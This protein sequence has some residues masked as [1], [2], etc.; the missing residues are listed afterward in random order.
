MEGTED[1]KEDITTKKENN[2]DN[3]K[4]ASPRAARRSERKRKNRQPVFSP[5]D[6]ATGK[7]GSLSS[8]STS[9][10]KCKG[11]HRQPASSAINR[12][13]DVLPDGKPFSCDLCHSPY[14]CNP[15]LSKGGSRFHRSRHMPS[16]RQK[17]SPITG[18]TLTLCNAC[19]NSL[20]GPRLLKKPIL[21]SPEEKEAYIAKAKSFAKDVAA[22]VQ[23]SNA[24]KLYCPSFKKRPCGCLQTHLRADGNK[25]LMRERTQT[26]LHLFQEAKKLA[27]EKVYQSTELGKTLFA[28]KKLRQG[29]IGLGNGMKRSARFESF[30]LEKRTYLK[31]ELRLCERATQRILCYSNN[32]LHKKL[33]TEQRG[34]RIIRQK[35]KAAMGLLEPLEK[36]AHWRCCVDHCVRIIH[37]HRNLLQQWRKRASISQSEA[38]RVLAE[39][40]T[41][42]GGVR[43]NCYKFIGWITGCSH[44]TIGKVRDHMRRTKGDREPPAHGLLNYRRQT[45]HS[46]TETQ[47]ATATKTKDACKSSPKKPSS[48]SNVQKSISLP[49]HLALS[50]VSG[51]SSSEKNAE[52]LADIQQQVLSQLAQLQGA[53]Q[54]LAS[55]IQALQ[56]QLV[57]AQQQQKQLS[58]SAAQL[59]QQASLHHQEQA[60]CHMPQGAAVQQRV[61]SVQELLAAVPQQHTDTPRSQQ[62]GVSVQH[63]VVTLQQYQPVQ[64]QQQQQAFMNHYTPHSALTQLNLHASVPSLT[65]SSY[66]HPQYFTQ[67]QP[68]EGLPARSHQDTDSWKGTIPLTPQQS[69]VAFPNQLSPL[70]HTHQAPGAAPLPLP[71]Q[72]QHCLRTRQQEQCLAVGVPHQAA[73]SMGDVMVLVSQQGP[74]TRDQQLSPAQQTIPVLFSYP[75]PQLS[76]HPG[77]GTSVTCPWQ[78]QP[79][80]QAHHLQPKSMHMQQF[81]QH[82]HQP[83]VLPQQHHLQQIHHLPQETDHRNQPPLRHQTSMAQAQEGQYMQH[84]TGADN[85][86]PTQ[87]IQPPLHLHTHERQLQVASVLSETSQMQALQ[88]HAVVSLSNPVTQKMIPALELSVHPTQSAPNPPSLV[89]VS[90]MSQSQPGPEGRLPTQCVPAPSPLASSLTDHQTASQASSPVFIPVALQVHA[91]RPVTQP[92]YSVARE[93]DQSKMA[94]QGTLRNR[95]EIPGSTF[96]ASV[97]HHQPA[98]CEKTVPSLLN[99]S[100]VALQSQNIPRGRH[101]F[102]SQ[103]LAAA[104]HHKMLVQSIVVPGPPYL[105]LQHQAH[106]HPQC[107]APLHG[108][109]TV[110][111]VSHSIA[112][113]NA[114]PI[115]PA[116]SKTQ[117]ITVPTSA[118]S[119]SQGVMRATGGKV[120]TDTCPTFNSSAPNMVEVLKPKCQPHIVITYPLQTPSL[121]HHQ[122]SMQPATISTLPAPRESVGQSVNAPQIL[123]LPSSAQDERI[124]GRSLVDSLHIDICADKSQVPLKVANITQSIVSEATILPQQVQTKDQVVRSHVNSLDNLRTFATSETRCPLQT[125]ANKDQLS[126][127]DNILIVK[128]QQNDVSSPSPSTSM[129]SDPLLKNMGNMGS[130]KNKNSGAYARTNEV[131]GAK[132][133][134]EQVA[135]S[136]NSFAASVSVGELQRKIIINA[137]TINK[138]SLGSLT[139]PVFNSNLHKD[140]STAQVTVEHTTDTA[141]GLCQKMCPIHD[142]ISASESSNSISVLKPVTICSS[143]TTASTPSSS[144]TVAMLLSPSRAPSGDFI[145]PIT[146]EAKQP[147]MASSVNDVSRVE[148]ETFQSSSKTEPILPACKVPNHLERALELTTTADGTKVQVSS[149]GKKE[150]QKPR[151]VSK[152]RVANSRGQIARATGDDGRVSVQVCMQSQGSSSHLVTQAHSTQS[153]KGSHLAGTAVET[154]K[155]AGTLSTKASSVLSSLVTTTTA[156]STPI[157]AVGSN[158]SS[159]QLSTPCMGLGL[160]PSGVIQIMAAAS[161]SSPTLPVVTTSSVS[162]PQRIA[163][164]ASG[165]ASASSSLF[166]SAVVLNQVPVASLPVQIVDVLPLSSSGSTTV[167]TLPRLPTSL[168]VIAVGQSLASASSVTAVIAPGCSQQKNVLAHADPS[169]TAKICVAEAPVIKAHCAK[170]RNKRVEFAGGH[171]GYSSS[172]RTITALKAQEDHRDIIHEEDS[173]QRSLSFSRV[174]VPPKD[175]ATAAPTSGVGEKEA[176]DARPDKNSALGQEMMRKAPV[177][178]PALLSSSIVSQSCRAKSLVS[179]MP[180]AHTNNLSNCDS[181]HGN[182]HQSQVCPP[183]VQVP[184]GTGLSHVPSGHLLDQKEQDRLVGLSGQPAFDSHHTHVV[185]SLSDKTASILE[186]KTHDQQPGQESFYPSSKSGHPKAVYSLNKTE[187][188]ALVSLDP[189][190]GK[191]VHKERAARWCSVPKPIQGNSSASHITQSDLSQITYLTS[192]APTHVVE[193]SS[194]KTKRP[195]NLGEMSPATRA[196]C[197]PSSRPAVI[198]KT[199]LVSVRPMMKSGHVY[200]SATELSGKESE[201]ACAKVNLSASSDH[202]T[203]GT[204]KVSPRKQISSTSGN[205]K[206]VQRVKSIAT[207]TGSQL[208]KEPQS[209]QRQLSKHSNDKEMLHFPPSLQSFHQQEASIILPISTAAASCPAG[210]FT[211]F[212]STQVFPGV[213]AAQTTASHQTHLQAPDAYSHPPSTAHP[214]LASLPS[215]NGLTFFLGAPQPFHQEPQQTLTQSH[216]SSWHRD[217]VL[218]GSP[219]RGLDSDLDEASRDTDVLQGHGILHA[220]SSSASS[221]SRSRNSSG[222]S[223]IEPSITIDPASLPLDIMQMIMQHGLAL[224]VTEVVAPGTGEDM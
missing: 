52:S 86:Q 218:T 69:A 211:M 115:P 156:I 49:E 148:K 104:G 80:Q 207:C 166:P 87:V 22:E 55:S 185:V 74:S 34:S 222:A 59:S 90:L 85:N 167:Q 32:F 121:T 53:Q 159:I 180:A 135:S 48:S 168:P 119:C 101:P 134:A 98:F 165:T 62:G 199:E 197:R 2:W 178:S 64:Q 175:A 183:K 82:L 206:H 38:R 179:S 92:T 126:A 142:S 20:D 99:N 103:N 190:V 73:H 112:D 8:A 171:D 44:S 18:K 109:S 196:D 213:S 117:T 23:D 7:Q 146:Q 6:F 137:S 133:T 141:L 83:H 186:S 216:I 14:V 217:G 125:A 78:Q 42:S 43:S 57:T 163:S 192:E 26:L 157:P 113:S 61:G 219:L 111:I 153:A 177:G 204:V 31:K 25:T 45:S 72:Q 46:H 139:F 84:S 67:T 191:D 220:L 201:S 106:N 4:S 212:K 63:S 68:Q 81:Q 95:G 41:P 182:S 151:H 214:L 70:L 123:I 94:D 173:N 124:L 89:Q 3:F 224:T 28:K 58:M 76:L 129:A 16:P 181:G 33:K 130:G 174:N 29:Q 116:Y 140:C 19:G 147:K 122:S 138:N 13:Y 40:L 194:S 223:S 37:S 54:Q 136:Q 127:N 47:P 155:P 193:P 9:K 184:L 35:G 71:Q 189:F 145:T 209:H 144:R 188:S 36:I 17:I 202:V 120:Q 88:S 11:R 158:I 198:S 215:T 176:E 100:S 110:Q 66:S 5:D 10:K 195:V 170:R 50:P 107:L 208:V 96:S 131:S 128:A 77:L 152:T 12:P 132:V 221:S 105:P 187:S 51:L 15:L 39:M 79:Q 210:D 150:K 172:S 205:T 24:E 169:E 93:E 143:T 161:S 154:L 97:A 60:A 56:Q 162:V 164:Q 102:N 1:I 114:G 149:S 91:P 200:L 160:E 75:Q 118:V 65:S 27:T 30:I 108:S 203:S 21:P